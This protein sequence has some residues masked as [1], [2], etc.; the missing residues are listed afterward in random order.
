MTS[1]GGGI[2]Y[3]VNYYG[4][5]ARLIAKW[6]LSNSDLLVSERLVSNSVISFLVLHQ[7]TI[8]GI[9]NMDREL[10]PFQLACRPTGAY[11]NLPL[12]R[13]IGVELRPFLV[14]LGPSG[15]LKGTGVSF[16]FPIGA[17]TFKDTTVSY[18]KKTDRLP[19]YRNLC[20]VVPAAG[21]TCH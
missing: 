11:R 2:N 13:K 14:V 19:L 16:L 1:E 17:C 7:T 9:D 6:L 4:I 15:V 20:R 12:Y 18:R 5:T 21:Q 10:T 3:A 8:N